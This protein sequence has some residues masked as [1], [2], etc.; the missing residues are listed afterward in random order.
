MTIYC[1]NERFLIEVQKKILHPVNIISKIN[2]IK[3]DN[4]YCLRVSARNLVDFYDLIYLYTPEDQI[5]KR[6]RNKFHEIIN[7]SK[8]IKK[9][10]T[11]KQ[12]K[13]F[14]L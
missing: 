2:F 12:I 14:N 9:T 7:K 4:F 13:Y 3:R 8:R 11:K 10:L 6:K 1:A 5:L